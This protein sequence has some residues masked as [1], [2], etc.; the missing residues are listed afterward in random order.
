[1]GSYDP[2]MRVLG[3]DYG[4][5]RIGVAVSDPSGTLARPLATVT[6]NEAG[7]VERVHSII[8]DL[9]LDEDAPAMIV[10]GLPSKLDGTPSEMTARVRAFGTAL[11]ER[12]GLPV[13]Y[14]DERLSSREA[15][16][17]LAERHPTW[18]GRK[19]LL[20][21][22]A[23]AVILQDYLDARASPGPDRAAPLRE[24]PGR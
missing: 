8:A 7:A 5:K 10:I 16:G 15:E 1:V 13:V 2:R 4:A 22:A 14:Q 18:R 3:L 21:A 24:D 20:D 19:A 9:G 23:A 17:R 6:A 11:A 12:T